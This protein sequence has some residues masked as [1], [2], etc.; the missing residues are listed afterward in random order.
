M[1]SCLA[2]ES[3]DATIAV[4]A[5]KE[6]H[7]AQPRGHADA[8]FQ[9]CVHS[10]GVVTLVGVNQRIGAVHFASSKLAPIVGMRV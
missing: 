10:I 5:G 1:T 8:D 3:L 7:L 6:Q 4:C 9:Q 2:I